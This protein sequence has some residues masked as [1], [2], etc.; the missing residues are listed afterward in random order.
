[1]KFIQISTSNYSSVYVI[2]DKVQN[3]IFIGFRGTSSLKSGLSYTKLSSIMPYNVC[4]VNNDGYVLG[5]FKIITEIFYTINESID[6]LSTNFLKNKNYKIVT[7]GHSLGG[8]CSPN[9]FVYS[10]IKKERLILIV[11]LLVLLV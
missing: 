5:V 10:G 11:L 8:G 2:A 7:T 4:S 1:M 9:I 6:F 3:T